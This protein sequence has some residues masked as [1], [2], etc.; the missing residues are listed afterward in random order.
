[1]DDKGFTRAFSLG[2][3]APGGFARWATGKSTSAR[4]FP[5]SPRTAAAVWPVL[6]W[7]CCLKHPED[8]ACEGAPFIR[9][10]IIRVAD[11]GFYDF[12]SAGV[13]KSQIAGILGL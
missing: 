10:H 2:S 13:D 12:A 1:M 9:R 7:E 4:Y 3:I 8:G 11:Q 5:A 6:E